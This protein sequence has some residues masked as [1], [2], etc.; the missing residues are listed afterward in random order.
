MDVTLDPAGRASFTLVAAGRD[1]RVSLNL[2]GA[3]HVSNALAAASVAIGL[4]ADVDKTTDAL[5]RA[6]LVASGRTEVTDRPDHVRVIND[7]FNANPDSMKAAL[8]ALEAMNS[9]RRTIAVLGEMKELG[10]DGTDGHRQ[11]GRL[12]AASGVDVLITV[13]GADAQAMADAAQENNPSLK[14]VSARDRD[15]ALTVARDLTEP[16]DIV[17]VKGS[18]SVGLEHT[19]E[20]LAQ[21]DTMAGDR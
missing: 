18:H 14:V 8:T 12:V 4:G 17:L 5:S 20:R 19:A 13:G 21:P 16:G 6:V 10:A 9:G 1:A 2:H 15:H 7:A 11:V 3:H